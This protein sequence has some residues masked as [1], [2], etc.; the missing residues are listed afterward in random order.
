MA[1]RPHL[2]AV[3]VDQAAA[4]ARVSPAAPPR[5]PIARRDARQF[6][7][8]PQSASAAVAAVLE[9]ALHVAVLLGAHWITGMPMDRGGAMLALLVILLTFPGTDRTRMPPLRSLADIFGNWAWLM[10]IVLMCG[11]VT[12]SLGAVD[13]AVFRIW[14]L[15]APAVQW[16]A[17]LAGHALVRARQPASTCSVKCN[18]AE[19]P[20][21][22]ASCAT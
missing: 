13:G 10:A 2:Q 18:P 1:P 12:A 19:S 21:S 4:D 8:A 7:R 3:P 20:T 6:F 14:A 9:P 11:W 15:A 16:G 22:P 5:V 17:A